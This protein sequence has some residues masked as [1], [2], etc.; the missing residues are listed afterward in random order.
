MTASLTTNRTG[1]VVLHP[2]TAAGLPLAV[3]HP[4]GTVEETTFPTTIMPDQPAFDIAG[5]THRVRGVTAE[6][7]FDGGMFEMED[8][9][10]WMDASFKTY[11]RPLRLPK[12]YVI[13]AGGTDRQAVHLRLSG[14]P[15]PSG[16][17]APETLP[18]AVMPR[19]WVRAAPG[20]AIPPDIP[21]DL[22]QGLIARVDLSQPDPGDLP[23]LAACAA[24]LGWQFGVEAL[25][26]LRDTATEAR[27]LLRRLDGHGVERLLVAGMRDLKSRPSGTVPPDEQPLSDALAA[28]RK[29]GF[30][31][32]I[33]AGTPAFFTEFNR[34]PPPPS[35]F[36]WF[37]GS[38]IVHAV[39]EV[40]VFETTAVIPAVLASAAALVPGTDLF[41]G[42]LA[43]APAL[44]PY[45]PTFAPNPRHGRVCMAET[46]P[47]HARQ[48]GAAYLAVV[49]ARLVGRVR[50]A[51]PLF[52]NGPSGCLAP[53][54]SLLLV[55]QVHAKMAAA[56][57][58][59]LCGLSFQGPFVLLTWWCSSGAEA[60]VVLNTSAVTADFT[61]YDRIHQLGPFGISSL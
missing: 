17:T 35:D 33:G 14:V 25:F 61:R 20:H 15:E 50:E 12:P 16:V 8:Q 23:A 48:V 57:G 3:T 36:A 29:V 11:V 22:A 60:G 24:A 47:R 26:P 6:V 38:A 42:P 10:N 56:A 59:P 18:V 28:L 44:S 40:S 39:D 58:S 31:G 54:G 4:D 32:R 53:D 43:I 34:N 45:A 27:E 21:P 51:A 49:I 2:D 19:L 30:A 55:G 5:L 41:P 7:T 46:D 52:L 13:P 9:R 1:F 37:G